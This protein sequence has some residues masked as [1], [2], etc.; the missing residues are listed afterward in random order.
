MLRIL[1]VGVSHKRVKSKDEEKKEER[2]SCA[3]GKM[4][5]VERP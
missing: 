2:K 3:H 5:N 1:G 4:K